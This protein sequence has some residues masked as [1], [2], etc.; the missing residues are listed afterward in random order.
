M[1]EN[2]SCKICGLHY[3]TKE[4]KDKCYAW[5]SNHDSCNLSVAKQSIE[6]IKQKQ[7]KKPF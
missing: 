7:L 3:K 1:P 2:Y 6:A 5:C 4:L